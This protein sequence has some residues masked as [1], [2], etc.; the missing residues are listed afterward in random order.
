MLFSIAIL[1]F[2]TFLKSFI[3]LNEDVADVF[4]EIQGNLIV[5]W[6]GGGVNIEWSNSEKGTKV[7]NLS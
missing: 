1:L 4:I 3:S 6:R 2:D 5:F 7:R